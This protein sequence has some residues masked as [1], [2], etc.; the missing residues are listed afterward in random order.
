MTLTTAVDN[1]I[2]STLSDDNWMKR[3]EVNMKTLRPAILTISLLM[4]VHIFA[5]GVT[6]QQQTRPT[7]TGLALEVTYYAGRPPAYQPVPV[8]EARPNGTWYGHFRRVASLQAP[9]GALS[10]YAVNVLSRAEGDAVRVTIS[11]FLRQRLHEKEVPVA[12]YLIRV[13]EKIAARDMRKFG[14]EPFEIK[15]IRVTPSIS[16]QP[17]VR[18]NADSIS[19]IG[20]A[21]SLSTLP[22]TKIILQN[23]S[24]QDVLALGVDIFEGNRLRLASMPQGREGRSLIQ[25]GSSHTLDLL[26]PRS[27]VATAQGYQPETPR[28]QEVVITTAVF[29]DASYQGDARTAATFRGNMVG[30]KIQVEKVVHMLRTFAAESRPSL[31]NFKNQIAGL[32]NDVDIAAVDDIVRDL[33]GFTEQ[34]RLEIKDSVDIGSSGVKIDLLKE[35]QQFVDAQAPVPHAFRDWLVRTKERYED[36]LSR[37]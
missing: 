33:S 2:L 32:P 15:V 9:P 3:K 19:V 25:A 35:L 4:S 20:Q 27:A 26:L 24:G 5:P 28:N 30:R 34:M 17:T 13:D 14:L 12:S 1:N 21:P 36:W 11:L 16:E 6:G 7:P 10:V 31:E 29:R 22:T 23:L 37:L 18:S 8:A